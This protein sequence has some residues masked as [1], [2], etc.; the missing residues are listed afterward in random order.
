MLN[1][2]KSK[3]NSHIPFRKAASFAKKKETL[4]RNTQ[5]LW[6]NEKSD[7]KKTS[8]GLMYSWKKVTTKAAKYQYTKKKWKKENL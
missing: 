8:N 5:S 4:L 3:S 1:H 6:Q 7:K 2:T